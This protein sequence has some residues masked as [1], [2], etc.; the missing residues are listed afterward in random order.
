MAWRDCGLLDQTGK[1]RPSYQVWKDYF[2]L[3]LKK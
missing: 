2:S 3:P 1:P